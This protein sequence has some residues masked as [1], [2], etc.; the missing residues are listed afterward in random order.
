M[1]SLAQKQIQAVLEDQRLD[2]LV[3]ITDEDAH[4]LKIDVKEGHE[5]TN[6]LFYSILNNVCAKGL[7]KYNIKKFN[8][9]RDGALVWK[10]LK[11]YYDQDGDKD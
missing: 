10:T 9:Q 11:Q 7:A 5:E 6:Q 3:N 4:G 1:R 8:D 2:Q